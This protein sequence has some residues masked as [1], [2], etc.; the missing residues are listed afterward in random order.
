MSN[1]GFSIDYKDK[2]LR[3]EILSEAACSWKEYL[4]EI[5]DDKGLER[6]GESLII[7]R[8]LGGVTV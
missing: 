1:K 8:V 7:I 3:G 5:S 6:W 2:I 4:V